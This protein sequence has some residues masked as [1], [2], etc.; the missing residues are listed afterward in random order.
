M[1]IRSLADFME[2]SP[3]SV[4]RLDCTATV[5]GRG[6]PH[7]DASAR[8]ADFWWPP[9]R[10]SHGQNCGLFRGHGQLSCFPQ[11]HTI[12]VEATKAPESTN[13][14]AARSLISGVPALGG[15]VAFGCGH[16]SYLSKRTSVHSFPVRIN[17]SYLPGPG[18][19]ASQAR[20]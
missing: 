9:V 15:V 6:V 13:M 1:S 4:R 2:V 19:A 16:D 12:A 5:T 20:T 7:V 10:T 3:R 18:N 8:S 17:P 14:T 11:S